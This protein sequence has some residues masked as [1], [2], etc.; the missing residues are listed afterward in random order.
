MGWQVGG[1]SQVEGSTCASGDSHMQ[2]TDPRVARS[3]SRA[4]GGREELLRPRR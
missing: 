3:W 2:S 4:A 1:C